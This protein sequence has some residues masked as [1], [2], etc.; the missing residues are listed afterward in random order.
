MRL[1]YVRMRLRCVRYRRR[2]WVRHWDDV[3]LRLNLAMCRRHLYVAVQN[4]ILLAEVFYIDLRVSR[5]RVLDPDVNGA[6]KA[7]PGR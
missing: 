7:A 1:R 4:L 3:E 6:P 2:R 5:A